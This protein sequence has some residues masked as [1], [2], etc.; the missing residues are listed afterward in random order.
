MAFSLLACTDILGE[1][2]NVELPFNAPP[3]TVDE[4]YRTLE[5]VFRG[6]EHDMKESRG[7][8]S[9]RSSEPFTVSR[10]QRYEEEAQMWV[11]LSDARQ[12]QVQDQLYVFR[13]NATKADISTHREIPLPRT[14]L[15]E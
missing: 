9:T 4:L 5:R 6:E 11:E 2:V 7:E 12:L 13:K 1:K 15:L 10:L 8:K 3:A 14:D